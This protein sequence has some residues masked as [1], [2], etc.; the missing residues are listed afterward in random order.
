MTKTVFHAFSAF[1]GSVTG[2]TTCSFWTDD[3]A[4]SAIN[5][6]PSKMVSVDLSKTPS[7]ARA[8]QIT[9]A[10]V[11][12]D[13]YPM[14]GGLTTIGPLF[15][16]GQTI[17]AV[18]LSETYMKKIGLATTRKP[19]HAHDHELRSIVYDGD[20][21]YGDRR[22]QGFHAK[23]VGAPATAA[24]QQLT[25]LQIWNAGAGKAGGHSGTWWLD[26]DDIA[27][28]AE[29][30]VGAKGAPEGSLYLDSGKKQ[31][32]LAGG[33]TGPKLPPSSGYGI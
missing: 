31:I 28:V 3:P 7:A 5:W 15:P 32:Y 27:D 25:R 11:Q 26:L 13:D 8:K 19:A 18:W 4:S 17:G 33:G 14:S 30:D 1:V 2:R 22:F 9:W 24:G 16:G 12:V 29:S 6:D 20:P 23:V 21:K 10:D